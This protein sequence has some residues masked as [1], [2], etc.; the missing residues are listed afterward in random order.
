MTGSRRS[1]LPLSHSC[2]LGSKLDPQERLGLS[3]IQVTVEFELNPGVEPA[4]EAALSE[5]Q[6]RV[7]GFDGYLG[8]QPCRSLTEQGTFVSLF[9]WRDRESMQAWRDDPAHRLIQQRGRDEFFAWYRIRVAEI[10]RD[11]GL[12]P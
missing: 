2:N 3:V 4:F 5:M 6:E 11:Y 1:L 10:E 12:R 7:S 9:Y 8:E